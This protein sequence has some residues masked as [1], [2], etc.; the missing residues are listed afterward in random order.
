[1]K[2][3]YY[4]KAK[5]FASLLKQEGL[6]EWSEKILTALDIGVTST[7]ILMMLRWNLGNF[8]ASKLGSQYAISQ[9]D[10]LYKKIDIELR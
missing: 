5:D 1:M 4:S 10:I 8:L 9:A 6:T 3:D 2:Y 7:E